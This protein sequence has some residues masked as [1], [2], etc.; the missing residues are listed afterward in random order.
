MSEWA[1]PEEFDDYVI[2]RPL[3][4]G[5][6]GRVFLA[7]D[8]VLARP[9][10]V[11]FIAAL[12]PDAA[13]RQ[14]F[15]L[16]AR[17]TARLQHPNVVAI[18]RVGELDSKP[19][20]VTE[21][22][23]GE[24]L[25]KLALP[26]PAARVLE[27]GIELS[28][29]LAAAHR[30]G[31]IHGDIKPANA[32]VSEDGATKLLDFGLATLADAAPA[33]KPRGIA[34]TPDYMAPELWR[35]Q[36]A[37]RRTDVYA[38]GGV[39][40]HLLAG[41][42]AFHDVAPRDLPKVVQQKDAPRLTGSADPRLIAAIDRCL[43][44]DPA[45]RWASGDE[46][47]EALEQCRAAAVAAPVIPGGNPY[48]GLRPF[49][50]DH[51]QLFFGRTAELGVVIDR[52]RAEPFV[53]VAGDSGSGKSSLCRAAVVPAVIDGALGDGRTWSSVLLVPG[54]RPLRALAAALAT[55]FEISEDDATTALR[56]DGAAIRAFIR[57]K[58]GAGRGLVVFVD[59]LEELAT[60]ADA[61]EA[62]AAD[63]ALARL[64][65]GAPGLRLL[66]TARADFLGRLAALP[67]VGEQLT[68][69]LSFLRPLG[70]DEIREVIVGP[71][72]A[73][74]VTFET[75]A[76]V[77]EL[78]AATAGTDGGLP[79]LQFALAELWA[80]RD[81]ETNTITAAA[82]ESLGG[83]EGALARHADSVIAALTP[84]QQAAARR[85][86]TRLITP[87]GTRARRTE[88]ELL[89]VDPSARTVLDALV[90]GR[91][92]VAHEA[93]EGSAYELSHEVLV[94][95]WGTL[96]QWM[97]EDADQRIMADRVHAAAGEW[98]RLKRARDALWGPRQLGETARVVETELVPLD[99]EF[100]AASRRKVVRRRW[101]IRGAIVAVPA[102]V[103]AIYFGVQLA[104]ERAL[105]NEVDRL[106]RDAA[107]LLATAHEKVRI[108]D[109]RRKLAFAK[110]DALDPQAEQ[111]WAQ[112]APQVVD[113]DRALA[114][115]SRGYE[116]ALSRDPSRADVRSEFGALLLE[117]AFRAEGSGA[118]AERDELIDRVKVYDR[119]DRLLGRW[120]AP[121][122]VRLA[123]TPP[124]ATIK[125]TRFDDDGNPALEPAREVPA[126]GS[127]DLPPGSY[128]LIATAPQRADVRYPMVL[129]RGEE[130]A[131]VIDLPAADAIPPGFVPIPAGEFQFGSK[132][133]EETRRFL[134]TVP[135]HTRRTAPFLIGRHE[136]TFAEW[137]AFLDTLPPDQRA[138][139]TPKAEGDLSVGG[140]I[141]MVSGS[142]GWSLH[143]EL[144]GQDTAADVGEP[145]RYP[146]RDRRIEQDW[147]KFPV[148]GIDA[149]NGEAYAAWLDQSG[150]VRGAR[151]CT[152]LEWE[153]AARGADRRIY[154]HGDRLS[155][156]DANFD[157]TYGREP[158]AQGLDEVGSHPASTS[159]FG[160]A[161]MLGNAFEWT[162]S[163][164][165][166]G[167]VLR[168]GSFFYDPKTCQL[169]N[170]GEV[171]ATSRSIS[172]GVRI[173]APWPAEPP[174]R[175]E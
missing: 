131:I 77:D 165:G 133:D 30:R 149:F 96:R 140:G 2:E 141:R 99:R 39:L 129:H 95:G 134:S 73:T 153:R 38:L 159:P 128:V 46:L 125:I 167:Y 25:D 81:V 156:D 93:D 109:E 69:A 15:L 114:Q 170:R 154:P 160:L 121:I 10:A 148:T 132:S 151:L 136:V 119:G 16:E 71:A 47:R 152:E 124:T 100:L 66:A 82:L 127:I 7:H 52:L 172:L 49:E 120:N 139:H 138:R 1:P 48:R 104:N 137:I 80:A 68:R 169:T 4:Q 13:S 83:V 62:A 40:Y 105:R 89:A 36:P 142:Q 117:R 79:L 147:L 65:A 97:V 23:R 44:R 157:A 78:V 162:R 175:P 28:R 102:L 122:T 43:A 166:P 135:V 31:V 145:L 60:I 14:R 92:L 27:L 34:G 86:L 61:D 18:Y 126:T 26:A 111:L 32:I 155:P 76:M 91:L 90:R 50:A 108:A 164:L 112:V 113:A 9:V 67:D 3:A 63:R 21:F 103:V 116:I 130:A 75:E 45:E 150:L 12:E 146:K 101:A 53:L 8:A 94:R 35:G 98:D 115:A 144:G 37:D 173:C 88:A 171:L 22:V 6:M 17:A 64:G 24:T 85:L 106:K 168:G 29:G 11:K 161:D 19:Y 33:G 5:A 74:G 118:R 174:S 163:V 158:G 87:A 51:R 41:K 42:P 70:P 84:A 55:A 57:D 143:L 123:I 54:R 110:F 56:G 72:T 58:L 59:Q 107:A 20:I